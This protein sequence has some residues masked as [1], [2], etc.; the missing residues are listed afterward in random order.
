MLEKVV[1]Y[2]NL[3]IQDLEMNMMQQ[4]EQNLDQEILKLMINKSNYKFGTQ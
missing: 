1:Y 2:Y 3:Q 4:L